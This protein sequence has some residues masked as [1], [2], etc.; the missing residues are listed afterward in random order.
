MPPPHPDAWPC[1]WHDRAARNRSYV[2][3][4]APTLA[5]GAV[6]AGEAAGEAADATAAGWCRTTSRPATSRPPSPN[7]WRG[8]RGEERD[9][10]LLGRHRLRQDLHHGQGDRGGA[11]A[12]ADPGAQQDAGGAA[13]R[14]DEELLPGQRGGILR[15]LLRLLPAGSLRPAHRHLHREGRADQRAD[16]PHA[17]RRDAGAARAQRR[18]RSSP[19][20]P[21]STASARS[22]PTPRWW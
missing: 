9:Q 20:S 18:D 8:V 13:L 16:R 15:Q 5:A 14:R 2:P 12:D 10:V 11:E 22:R 21:A 19:R 7:W 1:V 6:H 3:D 4:P 17:P